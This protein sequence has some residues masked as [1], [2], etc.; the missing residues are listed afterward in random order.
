MWDEDDLGAALRTEL[1][2]RTPPRLRAGLADAVTRG[3]RRRR[4]QQFGAALAVVAAVAGVA[5]V[6]VSAG[7]L[8]SDGQNVAATE[9]TPTEAPWP[10]ADLPA[11]SPHATWTPAPSAPPPAGWPIEPV[12]RCEI[13]DSTGRNLD[14]VRA[15][16]PALQ[17]QLRQAMAAVADDAT[18]DLPYETRF[19]PTGPNTHEAF[20]Y[21]ADVSDDGG[22]GSVT[23]T[24][25]RFTGDPLTAAD[26]QAYDMANCQAPKRHV[27]ANG[28]VLQIYD[29][30]PSDPFASQNQTLRIYRPDGKLYSLSVRN[31]GSPDFA[32]NPEDTA[33]PH[34]VGPGRPTLPLTEGQLAELGLAMAG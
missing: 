7:A 16:L 9:T 27:L 15:D 28:T 2:Q 33:H 23:L 25:G 11:H 5:T 26:D 21:T 8:A 12:P 6:A 10:R 14:S 32:T 3:R 20:T 31:F 13:P 19:P 4:R 1:A 29:V 30:A 22:T 24:F 34:R 17:E 18:V